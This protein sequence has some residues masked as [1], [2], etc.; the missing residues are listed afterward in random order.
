MGTN[1]SAEA[2]SKKG[3]EGDGTRSGGGSNAPSGLY[4]CAPGG[5]NDYVWI[6]T[7]RANPEHWAR[8]CKVIGR[9]ELINDPRFATPDLRVK[10]DAELDPIIR[11]WT[12]ARTKHEAMAAVGGAGIPAGPSPHS[13]VLHNHPPS[14]PPRLLTA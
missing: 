1:F 4:P 14:Y 12:K 3:G 13:H 7:S 2:R 10:N 6:M 8:L 11:D 5:S 9:E